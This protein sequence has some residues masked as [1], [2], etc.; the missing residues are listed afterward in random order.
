MT[1]GKVVS[2]QG[3]TAGTALTAVPFLSPNREGTT[4]GGQVLPARPTFAREI[5]FVN[6]GASILE[7][8]TDSGVSFRD[9]PISA[10]PTVLQG[11]IS[12]LHVRT[13]GGGAGAFSAAI[14]LA[15]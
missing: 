3:V 15:A 8:T 2:A 11:V 7:V 12:T 6:T 14:T 4:P 13:K 1:G 5:N 10:F 9:V